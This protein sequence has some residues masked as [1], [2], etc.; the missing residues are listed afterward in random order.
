MSFSA[1]KRD[2]ADVAGVFFFEYMRLIGEWGYKKALGS[3]ANRIIVGVRGADLQAN[4]ELVNSCPPV[5]MAATDFQN[6]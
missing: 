5:N 3:L 1:K 2:V 6:R 4:V